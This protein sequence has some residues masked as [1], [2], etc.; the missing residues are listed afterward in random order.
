M[1]DSVKSLVS[2]TSLSLVFRNAINRDNV[3]K[4]AAGSYFNNSS[5]TLICIKIAPNIRIAI[6]IAAG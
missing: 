3:R 5:F 6:P 2:I 1:V 4:I